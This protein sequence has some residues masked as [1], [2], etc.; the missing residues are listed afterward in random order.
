MP[1]RAACS[2]ASHMTRVLAL[3][4]L[5]L[6]ACDFFTHGGSGDDVCN[7]AIPAD[8]VGQDVAALVL[9]NPETGVCTTFSGGGGGCNTECG[10]CPEQT[11]D[12]GAP[13]PNW[14]SC[15]GSCEGLDEASCTAN[16]SCHATYDIF[17]TADGSPDMAGHVFDSCWDIAPNAPVV[18]GACSGL[19]ATTCSMHADCVSEFDASFGPT[20]A[21]TLTFLD[22][23]PEDGTPPPLDPGTCDQSG[24]HCNLAPPACPVNT[25]PGVK[26][27]CWSGY[28]I[29]ESD[30][31][32]AACEDLTTEAA[33]KARAGECAPSYTGTNCTCDGM[34]VCTCENETFDHCVTV[35][36]L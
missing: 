25:V 36:R 20:D 3:T 21:K 31:P 28:C 13:I 12:L 2:T 18:G 23:L 27:G 19:D 11:A 34:G 32:V 17:A 35:G 15:F 33:C 16:P 30:C 24:V 4:C 14:P 5:L 9:R 10:P 1:W 7:K 8:G 29:P 22:C 26:D 6:G